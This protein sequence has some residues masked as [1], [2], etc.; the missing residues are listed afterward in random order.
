MV[1]T[2]SSGAAADNLARSVEA[3]SDILIDS[4]ARKLTL[5]RKLI[6]VAAEAAVQGLR[7]PLLG[8]RIDID[9]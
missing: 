1:Q 5:A 9:A 7:D 8:H 2:V 4:T 3:L 6:E